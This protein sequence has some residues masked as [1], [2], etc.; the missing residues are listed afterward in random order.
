VSIRCLEDL[1]HFDV[2][3]FL[4]TIYCSLT[5]G[6]CNNLSC[7]ITMK[8]L[9]VIAPQTFHIECLDPPLKVVHSYLRGLALSSMC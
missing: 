1:Y 5:G 2:E 6:F 7:S 4:G 3:D 8:A 9:F